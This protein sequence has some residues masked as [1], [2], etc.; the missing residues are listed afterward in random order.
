MLKLVGLYAAC[1]DLDRIVAAEG[2]GGCLAPVMLHARKDPVAEIVCR[3][4]KFLGVES[5]Q[6]G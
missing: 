6:I 5:L 2:H 1:A 4:I 3:Q